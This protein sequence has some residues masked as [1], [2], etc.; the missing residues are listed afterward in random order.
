MANLNIPFLLPQG[1]QFN[2]KLCT[3]GSKIKHSFMG[4]EIMLG[5]GASASSDQSEQVKEIKKNIMVLAERG[6]GNM[7]MCEHHMILSD[8]E[9]QP[10]RT[11]AKFVVSIKPKLYC[12]PKIYPSADQLD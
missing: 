4:A 9:D 12:V 7:I 11:A 10:S 5:G 1:N 2:F 3:S 6:T 8:K